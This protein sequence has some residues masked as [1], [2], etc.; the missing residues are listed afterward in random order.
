M[1]AS[2]C[3]GPQKRIARLFILN[4]PVITP[5]DKLMTL[6]EAGC[7][8][9]A[10]CAKSAVRTRRPQLVAYLLLPLVSPRYVLPRRA[11]ESGDTVIARQCFIEE[12]AGQGLNADFP[13]FDCV[14]G[15]LFPDSTPRKMRSAWLP[16]GRFAVIIPADVVEGSTAPAST[17]WAAVATVSVFQQAVG[18]EL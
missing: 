2:K 6:L 8:D 1:G 3:G 14:Q 12:V 17:K 16:R 13:R 11:Q 15:A 18:F 5:S 4:R 9:P 7:P 10:L